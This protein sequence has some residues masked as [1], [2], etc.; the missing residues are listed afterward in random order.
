MCR[1]DEQPQTSRS[2]A[3]LAVGE[4]GDCYSPPRAGP[5]SPV[6]AVPGERV[7]IPTTAVSV[8]APRSRRSSRTPVAIPDHEWVVAPYRGPPGLDGPGD[9]FWAAQSHS[10]LGRERLPVD[11]RLINRECREGLADGVAAGQEGMRLPLRKWRSTRTAGATGAVPGSCG[12]AD[13]A[14]APLRSEANVKPR[15]ERPLL[16]RPALHNRSGI[17]GSPSWSHQP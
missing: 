2:P 15:P 14:T 10:E 4:P 16:T 8:P 6:S 13:G 17:H 7:D 3:Q 9:F 12:S 11:V 1:V 5:P